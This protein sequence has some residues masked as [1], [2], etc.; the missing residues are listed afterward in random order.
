MMYF[1]RG[2]STKKP[3]ALLIHQSSLREVGHQTPTHDA[4]SK[5]YIWQSFKDCHTP[6]Y[7]MINYE[8][9]CLDNSEY[10]KG[11]KVTTLNLTSYRVS[12]CKYARESEVKKEIND[13]FNE[14]FPYIK[15]TLSKL[16]RYIHVT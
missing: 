11:R 4:N 3:P 15:L 16:R 14:M 5:L 6:R 2:G 13:Q 8:P 9:D 1:Y 12:F 10:F 7:V